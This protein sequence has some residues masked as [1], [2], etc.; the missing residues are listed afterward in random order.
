[1]ETRPLAQRRAFTLIELLVVIAIIALLIGILLPALGKARVSAR[2]MVSQSNL[3]QLAVA[4][5]TNASEKDEQMG[6]YDWQASPSGAVDQ[7]GFPQYTEYDIGGGETHTPRYNLEAA[8]AQQAAIIRKATG[9]FEGDNAIRVNTNRIPHRRYLHLPLI[10]ALTGQQPEPTAVSPLDIHHLDFQDNPLDYYN[11]PGGANENTFDA[12][13]RPQVV[14]RWPFASSY[15]STVYSWTSERPD[16]TGQLPLYPSDDGT[17]IYVRD[18]NAFFPRRM[19]DVVFPSSKAFFFEEFDYTK[20]S[21]TAGLYYADP[22]ADINVQ[23]FDSSVRRIRT[24][25][26]SQRPANGGGVA[27][28]QG[29]QANPGWNAGDPCNMTELPELLYRSI[30]QRFFQDYD[31]PNNAGISFPGF[32][33][34]TRGGLKGLDVGGGEIDTSNWC[35]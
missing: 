5:A 2:N 1:M 7:Y 15:Q 18:Q 29:N 34:W 17:L 16:E 21:G 14:N 31:I 22:N 8:Q 10:D 9:R 25:T 12:W 35:R 19:G 32:Y 30:D 26:P 28:W 33:K 27:V 24:G 23:F 11:L 13:S 6:G 4:N 20:G 3:K